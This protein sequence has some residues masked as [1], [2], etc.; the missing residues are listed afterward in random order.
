MKAKGNK[1]CYVVAY[2]N[3]DFLGILKQQLKKHKEYKDVEPYIPTVRV[4]KK[5]FKGKEQFEEVPLL[6]QYGFF[7]VPRSLAIHYNF[8]DSL[9][10]NISCIYAWVKD[11]L[12]KVKP[13]VVSKEESIGKLNDTH[14]PIATATSKEIAALI[15]ATINIGAHGPDDLSLLKRGDFII[16]KGY[17]YEGIEAEFLELNEKKGKVKVRI[18]MF[19]QNREVEVSYDNVFFTLYQNENYD[20]DKLSKTSLDAMNDNNT[21]DKLMKKQKGNEGE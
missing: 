19:S 7:K 18:I 10:E 3:R 15:R 21:L 16:L 5:K 6:F 20:P 2:I 9:K 17:P 8:L 4:L 14:V 1:Y 11:P 12:K 13:L